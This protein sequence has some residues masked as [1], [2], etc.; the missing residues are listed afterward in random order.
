[1]RVN[2]TFA[3]VFTLFSYSP[4]VLGGPAVNGPGEALEARRKMLPEADPAIAESLVILGLILVGKEDPKN[5]EPVLREGVEIRRK[6]LPDDHWLTANA[7]SVLGEC[8]T[9]LKRLDEAE[10]LLLKAYP[11]IKSARGEK[12]RQTLEALNRII[13]LYEAKGQPD[14][15]AKYR[16]TLPGP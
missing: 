7:E 1:M 12:H 3:T 9:A 15:P 14:K 10:P 2:H 13:G 16:A 8:L 11:I 6:S 4:L 5:A